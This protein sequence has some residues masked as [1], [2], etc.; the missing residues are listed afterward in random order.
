MC[1]GEN[2][3]MCKLIRNQHGKIAE[4][5]NVFKFIGNNQFENGVVNRTC[6]NEIAKRRSVSIFISPIYFCNFTKIRIPKG[7]CHFTPQ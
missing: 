2:G 5:D 4:W 3:D 1:S 7:N 6:F